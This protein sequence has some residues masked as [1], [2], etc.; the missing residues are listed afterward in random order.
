LVNSSSNNEETTAS[1][2]KK[3]DPFTASFGS[4]QR[5]E[6]LLGYKPRVTLKKG[7]VQL[8]AWHYDRAYPYGG[9]QTLAHEKS[10]FIA[11]K[12]IVSCLPND[13]ECLK[14]APVFPC[15]SECSHEAQCTQ[16]FY[17]EI[18]GWTQALT[19][20]CETV[21]YTL[22]RERDCHWCEKRQQQGSSL[23]AA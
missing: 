3:E 16:S 19:A 17:D 5:A 6:Q 11:S 1:D 12:G 7:I 23:R 18:M 20:N 21:L 8:L 15:A 10:D 22:D 13:K 2:E 14:A 4:I 9:G